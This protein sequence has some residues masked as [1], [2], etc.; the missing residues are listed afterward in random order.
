MFVCLFQLFNKRSVTV[1][2]T[3]NNS[4]SHEMPKTCHLVNDVRMG[5]SEDLLPRRSCPLIVTKVWTEVK[6]RVVRL[7]N[8]LL[9]IIQNTA[10]PGQGKKGGGRGSG[11]GAGAQSKEPGLNQRQGIEGLDVIGKRQ[12]GASGGWDRGL[13]GDV[14]ELTL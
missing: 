2:K 14:T 1:D 3:R 7:I 8:V 4:M 12:A 10:P 9:T 6:S 11:K 13:H 5:R